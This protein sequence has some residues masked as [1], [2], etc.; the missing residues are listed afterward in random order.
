MKRQNTVK[1]DDEIL[2]TKLVGSFSNG[3]KNSKVQVKK[4][5]SKRQNFFLMILQYFL[6]LCVY[7]YLRKKQQI[8]IPKMIVFFKYL[9]KNRILFFFA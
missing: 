3:I 6:G 1:L 7:L 5:Q 8:Y 2:K 9:N 4:K